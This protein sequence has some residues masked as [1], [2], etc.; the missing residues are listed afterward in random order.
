MPSG[1]RQGVVPLTPIDRSAARDGVA[2]HRRRAATPP[3]GGTDLDWSPLMARAQRGDREAYRRLLDEIIPYLRSLAA[4]HHRDP[5]DIEDI[6]QDM[7]LTLHAIR[8]TYDPARPFGPWL[9]AIAH[10]RSVDHLRRQRRLRSREAPLTPERETFPPA[11]TNIDTELLDRRALH[12]AIEDLP[13]GQRRAIRLLKLE[14]MS[15]NE[16]AASS[17]MSVAALK[18][19]THRAIKNLRKKLFGRSNAR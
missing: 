17:G 11:Q 16:A 13:T 18:L 8:H 1:P 7:L 3:S 14:E 4:R 15:L 5:Q 6:L 2:S 12:E 9:V 10:R 19:A